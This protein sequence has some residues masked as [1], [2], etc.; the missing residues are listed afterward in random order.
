MGVGQADFSCDDGMI[1]RVFFTYQQEQTG[2]AQGVGETSTWDSLRVW[3]GRNI[4]QFVADEAGNLNGNLL[5]GDT[6]MPIS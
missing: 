2:T 6:S 5:C 3:S 1:G 4:R